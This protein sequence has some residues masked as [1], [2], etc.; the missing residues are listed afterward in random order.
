[1]GPGEYRRRRGTRRGR[2]VSLPPVPR[3]V[4]PTAAPIAPAASSAMPTPALSAHV[5]APETPSASAGRQT[6]A[7]AL[8]DESPLPQYESSPT[9]SEPQTP[10]GPA[11]GFKPP[12]PEL[13]VTAI[14]SRPHF[15]Q[16]RPNASMAMGH[17]EYTI[18][19]SMQWFK[20]LAQRLER[21]GVTWKET[22]QSGLG[23]TIWLSPEDLR[24]V[25]TEGRWSNDVVISTYG[26]LLCREVNRLFGPDS[27]YYVDPQLTEYLWGDEG[28][29]E[30]KQLSGHDEIVKRVAASC[31]ILA[32]IHYVEHW[33]LA[34]FLPE[35][36]Q[37]LYLDPLYKLDR[38]SQDNGLDVVHFILSWW[39][40]VGATDDVH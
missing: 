30:V 2:S 10:S 1:M 21:G 24:T 37:Y 6:R 8:T 32:P 39:A 5:A 36:K 31:L 23:Y 17:L 28:V 35:S 27:V 3:S 19:P 9:G 38:T 40:S 18:R 11:V 16:L 14:Q 34:V 33:T 4:P 15:F 7:P 26:F 12:F 13:S 20:R 22:W 29:E 25:A